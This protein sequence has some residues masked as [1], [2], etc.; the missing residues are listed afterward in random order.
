MKKLLF[1][2]LGLVA[3]VSLN[4]QNETFPL[5]FSQDGINGT[6]ASIGKAGAI[7]ALG[8]DIMSASY[9]PAGLGLYRR[10]EMTLSMGLDITSS[11]SQFNGIQADDSRPS[12]NYGN[13]GF[14]LDI[15]NAKGNWRHVQLSFGLNR[16]M[17]FSNKTKIV[18][19]GLTSSFIN[20]SVLD[21]ITSLNDDFI[22]S[23]VV[24]TTYD[25]VTDTY[26]ISSV[27]ETGN[28]F[29]QI[30]SIKE[31]GYI[32]EFTMSLSGNYNNILYLGATLGIPFG[33]YSCKTAFSEERFV[34]GISTGY[35]NYNTQQDLTVAG[36]NL[37]LGAIVRPVSWV[38]L[39]AAIHTPTYFSTI[40]DY[41]AEVEYNS[42][43]GGWYPTFEYSMRSPWKFMGNLAF[44]IG[45][46][47]S[48]I[49]GTISLD[50]ER[51]DYNFMSF[52][53]DDDIMRETNLNTSIDNNFTGA[54][55]IRLGG[56]LKLDR[57]YLRAGYAYF[58]NPYKENVNDAAWNYITC[59]VGY[60][61]QSFFFDLAYAYGKTEGGKYY[62][63][64][65][66]MN[67]ATTL[68]TTKNLIQTTIGFKF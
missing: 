28:A 31:S 27:Y 49:S 52:S 34:S 6:A 38:R 40:D 66:D 19:P 21:N 4:A 65:N 13:M 48:P 37:K 60:K 41:Y 50:Y 36:I 44:V 33:S 20:D 39:G 32:N 57:L 43:S 1:F 25:G 30:K 26:F 10:S 5:L 18:R 29:N 67:P 62:M 53:F 16:L 15:D 55:N 24:D 54:N 56:E 9:N 58:G 3:M 45:N 64:T 47:K 46:N 63:Y 51:T 12:F 7:G 14:V 2:A 22:S 11:K 42:W 35:Y 17:N 23:G 61:G 8:G 59:G 68:S